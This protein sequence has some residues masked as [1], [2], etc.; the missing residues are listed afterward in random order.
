MWVGSQATDNGTAARQQVRT[1]LVSTVVLQAALVSRHGCW[2]AAPSVT[3]TLC[4]RLQLPETQ[5]S[6]PAHPL[7]TSGCCI[8]LS[9]NTH[10][11]H[12]ASYR[13]CAD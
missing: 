3:V 12:P 10:G 6:R 5:Q 7:E 4:T 9:I 1:L 11:V 13:V 8:H 2:V